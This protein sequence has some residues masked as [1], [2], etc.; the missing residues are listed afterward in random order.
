MLL[1]PILAVAPFPAL[2]TVPM[3]PRT[4]AM[5]TP[6]MKPPMIRAQLAGDRNDEEYAKQHL[7]NVISQARAPP[8]LPAS[9]ARVTLPLVYI[10]A[11]LCCSLL[12]VGCGLAGGT[13]A[14]L[15]NA[16]FPAVSNL[17]TTAPAPITA[18]IGLLGAATTRCTEM[19]RT[20]KLGDGARADVGVDAASVVGR[21]Q[22]SQTTLVG[23]LPIQLGA[24]LFANDA[25]VGERASA[26]VSESASAQTKAL[27]GLAGAIASCTWAQGVIQQALSHQLGW[28]DSSLSTPTPI[29]APALA[30]L[31]AAG[32]ATLAD[33]AVAQVLRPAAARDVAATEEA[34]RIAMERC[35]M[36]FALDGASS[37]VAARRAAAFRRLAAEWT[38]RQA[39]LRWR[40]EAASAA[41]CVAA[42]AAYAASGGSIFAPIV[43]SL[44]GQQLER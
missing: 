36:R 11:T 30:A 43:T 14:A 13:A 2:N 32:I 20:G 10:S 5:I 24:L 17:C 44:G 18:A 22:L 4:P 38:E 41:R 39:E 31:G 33:S 21:D 9:Q 26:T 28:I 27:L 8:P 37:D 6:G 40:D 25:S 1:L 35:E 3:S 42:A 29:V 15:D 12:L 7:S 16:C 23:T 19:W 34:L